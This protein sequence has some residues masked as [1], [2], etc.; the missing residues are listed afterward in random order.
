VFG[1][2]GSL[3]E[4]ERILHP[5]ITKKIQ[6]TASRRREPFVVVEIPLLFETGAE[7]AY[8]TT[9]AVVSADPR[10]RERSLKKGFDHQKR[11]QH[12]LSQEEKAAK[13]DI[14]IENNGSIKDLEHQVKKVI[15]SIN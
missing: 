13:A 14:V 1:D 11:M 4:I 7:G 12:Q 8:D 15:D 9:I 6:E 5:R 2:E 10:C 3:R